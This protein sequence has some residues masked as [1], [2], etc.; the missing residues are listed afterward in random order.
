[1]TMDHGHS[2]HSRLRLRDANDAHVLFQA[3]RQGHFQLIRKRLT[4]PEQQSLHPGHVY[5]WADRE[6]ALERWT[7]GHCWS[8]S[9]VRG[10]FLM[11]DE[12]PSNESQDA[13]LRRKKSI[14]EKRTKQPRKKRLPAL[15]GGLS[16]QTYS[17]TLVEQGV[18]IQKWHLT[19][20]FTE[21]ASQQLLTVDEDPILSTIVVPPGI[22]V[23]SMSTRRKPKSSSKQRPEDDANDDSADSSGVNSPMPDFNGFPSSLNGFG[24]GGPAPSHFEVPSSSRMGE[25]WDNN[26]LPTAGLKDEDDEGSGSGG[27]AVTV[28]YPSSYDLQSPVQRFFNNDSGQTEKSLVRPISSMPK[29]VA[30]Q[31]PITARLESWANMPSLE[32]A[33][34]IDQRRASLAST[35]SSSNSLSSLNLSSGLG[36]SSRTFTPSSQ[37]SISPPSSSWSPNPAFTDPPKPMPSTAGSSNYNALSS[38]SSG[39]GLNTAALQGNSYTSAPLVQSPLGS[40]PI[41]GSSTAPNGSL[42]GHNSSDMRMLPPASLPPHLQEHPKVVPSAV[43][44][45]STLPQISR[46]MSTPLLASSIRTSPYPLSESPAS[47]LL[48]SRSTGSFLTSSSPF[49][50]ATTP[51]IS[52]SFP[53]ANTLPFNHSDQQSYLDQTGSTNGQSIN[54]FD[55]PSS[56]PMNLALLG[57]ERSNTVPTSISLT[58]R[59]SHGWRPNVESQEAGRTSGHLQGSF[60][61]SNS[62]YGWVGQQSSRASAPYPM[63]SQFDPM[64]PTTPGEVFESIIPRSS[65]SNGNGATVRSHFQWNGELE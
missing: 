7:D 33:C 32:N 47:N 16:K 20:Y 11:Y 59:S 50:S 10:P 43:P 23:S 38:W 15:P 37:S 22:F 65:V 41:V 25:Y 53:R 9:R 49:G 64:P 48:T 2:T 13:F 31:Q 61:H 30:S 24:Q 19:A 35:S 60:G 44:P 40:A 57:R 21:E 17:A 52:A 51:P 62:L 63:R 5:V 6:G 34:P 39:K 56:P 8:P 45:T 14:G 3:V 12:M 42:S 54:N 26:P 27:S 55:G 4:G 29:Y 18:P 36:D 58:S 46:R 28:T 1:M